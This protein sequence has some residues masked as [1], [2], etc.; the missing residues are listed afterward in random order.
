MQGKG[1]PGSVCASETE[2]RRPIR[3]A[4]LLRPDLRVDRN[5]PCPRRVALL[6]VGRCGIASLP[7]PLKARS[8][9]A[10]RTAASQRWRWWGCRRMSCGGYFLIRRDFSRAGWSRKH[11][12]GRAF[13]VA[14]DDPMMASVAGRYASALFE[15]ASEQ[16]QLREVEQD[17]VNLQTMLDEQRGPAPAGAQSGL[18]RR[19]PEP[20][21]C[22]C[23][24]EGVAR[25]ADR[26]FP[27]ADRTN[28]R[29]FALSDMIKS[30][31]AL[32]ARLR[33]EVI[34]RRHLRPSARATHSFRP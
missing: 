24:R 31:R 13:H 21:H 10:R 9:R 28:R 2:P 6:Q 15:L 18:H 11:P 26:Q 12:R 22:G 8:E 20:C 14:T 27:E 33:G 34:G 17:L 1:Y 5:A 30:F 3:R 19:G 7:H 25:C 4:S 29:L 32:A 23:C 16:R